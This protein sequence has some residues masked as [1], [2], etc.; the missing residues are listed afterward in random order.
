MSAAKPHILYVGSILPKRSETFVYREVLGLRERGVQ[1]SVASVNAPE[2][3]LG[4]DQLDQLANEAIHIYG[5]GL[6]GKLRVMWDSFVQQPVNTKLPDGIFEAG[7]GYWSKYFFQWNA[8]KGAG[9]AG[10]RPGDHPR[11]RPHGPRSGDR[12][13]ELRRGA[14]RTVQLHRPRRR[15]VPATVRR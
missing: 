12:G 9:P 4:D 8:G 2:R 15:P 10:K 3:D 6:G 1:V 7:L 11:P 13:D 5:R 14:R